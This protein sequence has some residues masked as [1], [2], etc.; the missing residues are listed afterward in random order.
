MA[1]ISRAFRFASTLTS[2][3]CEQAITDC[4][5]FDLTRLETGKL[6][7]LAIFLTARLDNWAH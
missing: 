2:N 6:P 3:G 4:A 1:W 5:A 7:D